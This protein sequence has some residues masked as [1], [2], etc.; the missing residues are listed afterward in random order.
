MPDC[1]APLCCR[2][3]WS[4]ARTSCQTTAGA[5]QRPCTG[6]AMTQGQ[7]KALWQKVQAS[8]FSAPLLAPKRCRQR[9]LSSRS[10][11]NIQLR[12]A[13]VQQGLRWGHLGMFTLA[14]I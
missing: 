3:R 1:L 10:T 5:P 11:A 9:L 14:G 2:S 6:A 12:T 8:G 13:D 7:T 4:G